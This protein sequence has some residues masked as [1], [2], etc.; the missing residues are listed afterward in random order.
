MTG[1]IV[2]I[3][4]TIKMNNYKLG[5]RDEYEGYESLLC[6]IDLPKRD[7]LM[8]LAWQRGKSCEEISGWHGLAKSTVQRRVVKVGEA[9]R[10]Y[11]KDCI[12]G[13]GL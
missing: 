12:I 5:S 9:M 3:M 4:E 6:E 1:L 11:V 7:K 10:A 13:Y 8:F 2:K